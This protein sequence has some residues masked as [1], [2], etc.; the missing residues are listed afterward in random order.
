M[1]DTYNVKKYINIFIYKQ[2]NSSYETMVNS[3][4]ESMVILFAWNLSLAQEAHSKPSITISGLGPSVFSWYIYLKK[5]GQ[6]ILS[7]GQIEIKLPLNWR[8]LKYYF[9]KIE[10]HQR[11]NNILTLKEQG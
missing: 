5:I 1:I 8:S 2:M 10:K 7:Y 4:Y 9:I 3:S 11:D 6:Y